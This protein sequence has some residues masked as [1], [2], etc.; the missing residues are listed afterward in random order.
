VLKKDPAESYATGD[1]VKVHR[2]V[3]YRY[4]VQDQEQG[5]PY[6]VAGLYSYSLHG[7]SPLSHADTIV[8]WSGVEDLLLHVHV[9]NTAVR[10]LVGRAFRRHIASVWDEFHFVSEDRVRHRRSQTPWHWNEFAFTWST[11]DHAWTT[12]CENDRVVVL[13]GYI[14]RLGFSANLADL[15]LLENGM[16]ESHQNFCGPVETVEEIPLV[17]G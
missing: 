15:Y 2:Y 13:S 3:Q 12:T 10:S 4:R 8:Q 5:E 16:V 17:S 7:F 1:T 9:D 6:W 14:A 11:V